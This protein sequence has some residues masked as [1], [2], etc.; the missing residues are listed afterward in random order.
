M[1]DC[2]KNGLL[3][4]LFNK[5]ANLIN[6]PKHSVIFFTKTLFEMD[7]PW[8]DLQ[9]KVLEFKTL[10]IF[11]ATLKFAKTEVFR[12]VFGGFKIFIQIFQNFDFI[13]PEMVY[14]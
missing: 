14:H 4:F 11:D 5:S 9:V 1:K 6:L 8:M 12:F 7:L 13:S 10:L 2:Y 3:Q